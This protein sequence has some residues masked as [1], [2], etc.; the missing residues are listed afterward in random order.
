MKRLI[1]LG[2]LLAAPRLLPAQ[3]VS[4]DLSSVV[5]SIAIVNQNVFSET[6]AGTS[7]LFRL[8]NSIRVSTRTGVVRRELLFKVGEPYDSATAA[9]TERNLR[10]LGIFRDVTIDTVRVDGRLT[11]V[12]RTADGWSTDLQLNAR[13]TGDEF[14]WAAGLLERNF[15]GSATSLGASYRNEPDRTAVA[16]IFAA[17]RTFGSRIAVQGLY[18]D[19]SDGRRGFWS[20]GLPFRAFTDKRSFNLAGAASKERIL[21]FRDGNPFATF[22]RRMFR[23][24]GQVAIA[25]IAT[26]AGYVRVGVVG[27]IKR[28]EYLPEA[29]IGSFVPDTVT[30]A[31]GVF[32]DLR[33]A[34]FKIVTHYNGFAREVDIDLST[35]VSLTTWLAP[36]AFGYD[37]TGVGGAIAVRTG[38]SLGRSFGWVQLRANGLFTASSGLDSGRVSVSITGV[39]QILSKSASVFHLEAGSLRRTAPGTEFD[40]G[41][42][43]GPRAFGVHAFTGTR[44]VW[45]SLEHRAFLADEVFGLLGLGV[46]G[47]V[48]YGGAWFAN[49]RARVGGDVGGGIRFG[50]TRATGPNIGRVDIAY[51]FGDGVGSSRWIV[52]FGRGFF[53]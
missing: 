34:R 44:T 7:F 41:H 21:Q 6:E 49:Q 11:A 22:R 32:A 14:T 46:A 33:K 35:R 37:E 20:M 42:G 13:S 15:L 8:A 51:R 48:D 2:I 3:V 19:L 27:Q 28:E 31:L 12:V 26:S 24:R 16:V 25:P 38:G 9:E 17:D 39:S 40:L 30:G 10:R 50:S 5:D 18:D 45:G 29:A 47:F 36:T 23:Q 53:F 52:L 1:S 43:V 4:R